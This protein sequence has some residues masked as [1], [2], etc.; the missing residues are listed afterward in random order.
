MELS[1]LENFCLREN[2]SHVDTADTV[3]AGD[4]NS[5]VSLLAPIGSPSVLDNPILFAGGLF[6]AIADEKHS[7]IQV[8]LANI[9]IVNDATLVLE[10]GVVTSSHTD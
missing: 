9:D 1:L 5:D 10:P 6:D 4:G 8:G 2:G 3:P 7:M